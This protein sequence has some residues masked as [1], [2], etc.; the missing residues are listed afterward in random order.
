[1]RPGSGRTSNL[2]A[3]SA[4]PGHQGQSEFFRLRAET[5][6]A[7]GDLSPRRQCSLPNASFLG[8]ASSLYWQRKALTWAVLCWRM[9]RIHRQY[10]NCSLSYRRLTKLR[11][12]QTNPPDNTSLVSV[13]HGAATVSD[14]RK[15]SFFERPPDRATSSAPQAQSSVRLSV[16]EATAH[17]LSSAH[18]RAGLNLR[19]APDVAQLPD[20]RP[21]GPLPFRPARIAASVGRTRMWICRSLRACRSCRAGGKTRRR[22]GCRPDEG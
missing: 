2:Y 9:M 21:S 20:C 18:G 16:S 12:V 17:N 3:Q 11:K 19:P 5:E 8:V 14:R 22:V 15:T 7:S 10:Q 1:M 13:Q 6:P 4:T